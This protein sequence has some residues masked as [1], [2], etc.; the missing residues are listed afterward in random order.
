M[1]R[2]VDHIVSCGDIDITDKR[3]NDDNLLDSFQTEIP[4]NNY[5]N[6]IVDQPEQIEQQRKE[7]PTRIRKQTQPYEIDNTK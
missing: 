6:N 4:E 5:P 3:P 1:K 7:Y 2:H